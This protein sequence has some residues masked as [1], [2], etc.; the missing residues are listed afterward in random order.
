MASIKFL[1]NEAGKTEGLA[2]A[3]FETFRGSPFTSCARETGQNS[4]DASAGKGAV[5]VSFDLRAIKRCDVPFADELQL[6]IDRCLSA[7]QDE[8]TQKHLEIAL[9]AISSSEI[10]V[11]EISDYNTTGLVGPIDDDTSVF[12]ALVKGDGITNKPDPTSAGSFG[13]GKN[14]AY[15]ISELQ[16]VI[17]S[18]CYEDRDT[19]EKQFAVQGRLRLISHSDG[20][21]KFS[22]EGYWGAPSFRAIQDS[23]EAP[24]WMRRNEVGTSIFS[25]G[26][27]QEDDWEKR[28]T[29]SLVNN[30]F[31]AIDRGDIEFSVGG[32]FS[33][34]RSSL[35]SV[36][37]LKELRDIAK[38]SDQ[39]M[40][41]ERAQQLVR[42]VRSE[43][44]IRHT[45]HVKGLGD[46]TLHL[47]VAEGLPREVHVVRNG[48]YI[49]DNFSKF[50]EPLRR[51]LGTK[52]FIAVLEP[53][54]GPGG[55]NSSAL[56]KQ[57]EN[58]A[59]DDFEPE[60]L[61]N[62]VERD[63]A[64]KQI[65]YLAAEIRK[66]I[67]SE[68]KL[69]EVRHSHIDELSSLFSDFGSAEGSKQLNPEKDPEKFIY[70]KARDR[71]IRKKAEPG[72]SPGPGRGEGGEV[73]GT[74]TGK[75]GSGKRRTTVPNSSVG[76]IGFRSRFPDRSEKRKRT[77]FFTPHATGN[78][79]LQ[80]LALGL[81]NNIAL[82]IAE[83]SVG[84]V[85]A[86]K[87]LL[88]VESDKRISL[89]VA[90]YEPFAGPVEI[91]L[92]FVSAVKEDEQ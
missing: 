52:E 10:K 73:S 35:D 9:A 7:P 53:S 24:V 70:G 58:P 42:C 92:S 71:A 17:Y 34:T 30:F 91:L 1:S 18:T 13:I 12:N 49:C 56:L 33:I 55:R 81:T 5:K 68:A 61:V 50:S 76:I 85:V 77:L 46:F 84:T 79:E 87:L 31:L 26:F 44:A 29:I 65:K 82:H 86:G 80:V 66:I 60:R 15:A 11:L 69:D 3:G 38:E 64:K 22:A 48:I 57:L 4:R 21:K 25:V 36:L 23:A 51:F 19:G 90:F 75:G 88:A 83:A 45:I 63:L 8:K 32:D 27:R 2:Y 14:A 67:K 47:L 74:R 72:D 78:V 28:M 54:V 41:L 6:A 20:D 43:A 62:K 40:E 16:T 37:G 39:L 59:H 89:D